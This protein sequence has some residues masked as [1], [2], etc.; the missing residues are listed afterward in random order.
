M[1]SFRKIVLILIY[2]AAMIAIGVVFGMKAL[3]LT[4][5]ACVCTA[6]AVGLIADADREEVEPEHDS[7][8]GC[9]HHL[10]G[11]HCRINV[12]DECCEGGG[13]ELYEPDDRGDD[14]C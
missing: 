8:I 7:C 1:R 3:V 10:G 11:G 5:V 14:E 6:I 12:E 2:S 13:F 9:K 4:V